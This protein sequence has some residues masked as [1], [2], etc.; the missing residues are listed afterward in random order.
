MSSRSIASARQKRA[1]EPVSVAANRQGVYNM[2]PQKMQAQNQQQKM[3]QPPQ[4]QPQPLQQT[5]IHQTSTPAP[6]N[7]ISVSDA[8]GLITIRLSRLEC[9]LQ[10]IE[11]DGNENNIHS[12]S[13]SSSVSLPLDKT[14]LNNILSRLDSLEKREPVDNTKI[15]KQEQ[16]LRD[17]KDLLMIHVMKFE[18][19][20]IE[21]QQC[22]KNVETEYQNKIQTL[23]EQMDVQ[24]KL[25]N[26]SNDAVS[27]TGLDVDVD[28]APA[29]VV[30]SITNEIKEAIVEVKE[31]K[32]GKNKK[33]NVDLKNAEYSTI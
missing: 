28:V 18:K 31:E 25:A 32:K 6:T 27:N 13:S 3:G 26:V 30:V 11:G 17:M 7:K 8:I 12:L 33:N 23:I 4:R 29:D 14:I 1:G 24:A 9:H 16:E 22:I 21:T 15:A 20:V 10:Q 19:F 2:P 5:Q